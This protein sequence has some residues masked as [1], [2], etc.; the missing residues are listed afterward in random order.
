M[1]YCSD[2][3]A[4]YFRLKEEIDKAIAKVLS[5]GRYILGDQHKKFESEFAEYIGCSY[6]IGVGN[7]T[8]AIHVALVACGIGPGDEVLTVSNTAVATVAA[9]E[10]AGAKPVFVDID[11]KTYNLDTTHIEDAVTKNTKAIV[12]VHLFGHPAD[13]IKLMGIAKKLDLFVIE[14]CAQAH[15][16]MIG[17]KMVGTF[18]DA[19]CFSFYPTKNL[20][21]LGDGGMVLTND[22]ALAQRCRLLREYGW[23]EKFISVSKGWNSRLDEIQAAILRVKLKYLDDFNHERRMIA[24]QYTQKLFSRCFDL[25]TIATNCKHVFHL[26][27]VRVK[28]GNRD[29]LYKRLSEQGVLCGIHYPVP[30][31]KQPAY[32]DKLLKLDVT[33]KSCSEILSLPIYPELQGSINKIIRTIQAVEKDII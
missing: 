27:V 21:A 19:S 4:Q 17:N 3:S 16:A 22:K 18:G 7:G 12:V 10:A 5:N 30:I 24:E 32:Y 1:I 13:M 9:I 23:S 29:R 20:G 15:G 26:F 25:P 33:E 31:H 6:G 14:D 11:T 8:E 28:D 2:P